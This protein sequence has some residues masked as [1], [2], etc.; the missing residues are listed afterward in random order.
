L[1]CCAG[2]GDGDGSFHNSIS[3]ESAEG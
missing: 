3:K 1:A 2:D